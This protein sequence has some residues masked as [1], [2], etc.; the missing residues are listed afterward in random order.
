MARGV[1]S[2]QD[3]IDEEEVGDEEADDEDED[4]DG[5]YGVS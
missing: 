5:L 2:T 3:Q 1:H 4:E